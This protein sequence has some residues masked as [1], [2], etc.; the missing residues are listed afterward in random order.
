MGI[1][2]KGRSGSVAYALVSDAEIEDGILDVNLYK[3]TLTLQRDDR[4]RGGEWVDCG[5]Q[6]I[7]AG[8]PVQIAVGLGQRNQ[9]GCAS[10]RV[11]RKRAVLFGKAKILCNL[12]RQRGAIGLFLEKFGVDGG[13][14]LRIVGL[15]ASADFVC[16]LSHRFVASRSTRESG[17]SSSAPASLGAHVAHDVADDPVAHDDLVT[18]VLEDE[19]RSMRCRRVGL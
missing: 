3:R 2:G 6:Q 15:S 14:L 11:E 10:V 13:G 4:V 19:P 7:V 5:L 8:N 16:C 1:Y 18:A 9:L 17:I 12:G